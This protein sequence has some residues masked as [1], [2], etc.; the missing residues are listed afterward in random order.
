M[1][2]IK[3]MMTTWHHC[4]VGDTCLESFSK[5]SLLAPSDSEVPAE[6]SDWVT[7]SALWNQC[8]RLAVKHRW[9][10]PL[11]YFSENSEHSEHPYYRFVWFC[12]FEALV[13][14]TVFS[15]LSGK[16][17]FKVPILFISGSDESVIYS[18]LGVCA[19]SLSLSSPASQLF[20]FLWNCPR[21]RR[22]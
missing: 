11:Q 3:L 9:L 16:T 20:H 6:L 7:A 14:I 4:K 19:P 21:A 17:S 2:K 18:T 12:R 10:Q 22:G 1:R 13:L 8:R 15:V 5:V